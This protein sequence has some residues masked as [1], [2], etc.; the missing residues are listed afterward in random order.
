MDYLV[1]FKTH[2]I[3]IPNHHLEMDYFMSNNSVDRM[4]NLIIMTIMTILVA[5]VCNIMHPRR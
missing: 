1:I 3:I 2:I 4:M 5:A